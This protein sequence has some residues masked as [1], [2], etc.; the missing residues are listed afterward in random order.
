MK[1]QQREKRERGER[2]EQRKES[3]ERVIERDKDRDRDTERG[4]GPKVQEPESVQHL[5]KN[6][7]NKV[8]DYCL[9]HSGRKE[10]SV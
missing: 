2:E 10:F 5:N 8:E 4:L 3:R 9:I 7:E 1:F 6:L